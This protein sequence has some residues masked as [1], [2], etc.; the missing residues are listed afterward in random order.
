MRKWLEAKARAIAAF[1]ARYKLGRRLLGMLAT[2]WGRV[3]GK[4]AMVRLV[5]AIVGLTFKQFM[6][7]DQQLGDSLKAAVI[8]HDQIADP[9]IPD[10]AYPLPEAD[11]ED[12][13]SGLALLGDEIRLLFSLPETMVWE[14]FALCGDRFLARVAA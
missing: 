3:N 11:W 6:F 10:P 13:A 1:L 9:S 7:T 14:M 8:E 12:F 4:E 5:T 2:L